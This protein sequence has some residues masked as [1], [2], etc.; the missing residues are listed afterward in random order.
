MQGC[1]IT[2]S[3]DSRFLRDYVVLRRAGVA[4]QLLLEVP[5]EHVVGV[6]A[7]F[8]LHAASCA[9]AQRLAAHRGLAISWN[10]LDWF[11]RRRGMFR[12]VSITD[13]R[14]DHQL[15]SDLGA[16]LAR[17]LV[18]HGLH[19]VC[20]E[21]LALRRVCLPFSQLRARLLGRL[22]LGS[23]QRMGRLPAEH[24]WRVM[25]AYIERCRSIAACLGV[26]EV[27][28]CDLVLPCIRDLLG[29]GLL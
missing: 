18:P 12:F 8:H 21:L 13:V 29:S 22:Y 23:D 15:R 26:L 1:H 6:V 17:H 11:S 25:L 7:D 20:E 4:R 27:A 9:E 2:I 5:E 10:V 19:R 3:T 14:A 16:L 24:C 28:S